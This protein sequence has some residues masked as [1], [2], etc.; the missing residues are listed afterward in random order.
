VEKSTLKSSTDGLKLQEK[1]PP[2]QLMLLMHQ[3]FGE[4]HNGEG[5]PVYR[6]LSWVMVCALAGCMQHHKVQMNN[7][8]FMAA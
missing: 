8:I 3:E 4:Q 2:P 5:L 7:I 6:Y 1:G